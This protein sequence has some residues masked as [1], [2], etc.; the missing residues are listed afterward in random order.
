MDTLTKAQ[1]SLRMSLV[2]GKDTKPELL[3]RKLVYRCGFRYRLHVRS[4]P[5]CPD[6]VFRSRGKVIFVHGCFWHRHA[7]CANTRLP[8]SRVHFWQTKLEANRKR[9]SRV[10]SQLTRSGWKYLVI[11]ECETKNSTRLETKIRKF[12][13]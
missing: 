1:R 8:K 11:W 10:K 9:D 4:I 5:G 13:Q 3:V 2:R 7:N 6:L 12:L